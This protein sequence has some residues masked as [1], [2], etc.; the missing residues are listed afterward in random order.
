M[1]KPSSIRAKLTRRIVLPATAAA[2][3]GAATLSGAGVASAHVSATAPTVTQGGYG[4]VTLAVPN[5]ADAAATTQLRVTMPGDGLAS[6]RPETTPGWKSIVT[7]KGDKVTEITWTAEPGSP[8]IPVGQFAQ[9][10]F[11]GGP[12]P[13][14]ET[15]MLPALQVYADG[16]KIDWN[17]PT[18]ADGT[19][20]QRPAPTLTLAPGDGAHADAHHAASTVTPQAGEETPAESADDAARWLGGVGLA[21]GV[22]GTVFGLAALM[23]ARKYGRFD[24]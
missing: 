13:E 5:E 8:G 1:K 14:Q 18:P 12:F 7:K 2:A 10:S 21:I 16:E 19:E 23:V 6:A 9:F 20:P 11:S 3:L 15:I 22:L 17:E 24:E 4:V